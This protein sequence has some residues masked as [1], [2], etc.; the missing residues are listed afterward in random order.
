MQ[1]GFAQSFIRGDALQQQIVV[2]NLIVHVI[3][4]VPPNLGEWLFS[5]HTFNGEAPVQMY[6]FITTLLY[7]SQQRHTHLQEMG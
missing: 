3:F 2:N 6:G 5:P 4:C 1:L 7:T